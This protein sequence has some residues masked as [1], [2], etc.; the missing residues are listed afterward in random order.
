MDTA[1]KAK[2]DTRVRRN[3]LMGSEVVPERKT[4]YLSDKIE[5]TAIA[6]TVNQTGNRISKKRKVPAFE[7]INDKGDNKFINK[8]RAEQSKK[9]DTDKII[10]EKL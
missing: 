3:K 2:I 7:S 8:L 1:R 10:N 6:R 5:E 9:I 4:A